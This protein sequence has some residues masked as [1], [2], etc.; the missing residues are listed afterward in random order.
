VV[1]V[2][3]K[4]GACRI[5]CLREL[6]CFLNAEWASLGERYRL[7]ILTGSV[8]RNH[9][10]WVEVYKFESGRSALIRFETGEVHGLKEV[11]EDALRLFPSFRW[12]KRLEYQSCKVGRTVVLGTVALGHKRL[13]VSAAIALHAHMRVDTLS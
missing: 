11:D 1:G 13:G 4:C 7:P 6:G 3:R 12:G 5:G 9:R 2:D 8:I 10:D